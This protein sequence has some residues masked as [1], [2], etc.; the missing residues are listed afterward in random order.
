MR[1]RDRKLGCVA[2]VDMPQHKA[3]HMVA[4]EV[5]G[6]GQFADGTEAAGMEHIFAPKGSDDR[7]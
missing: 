1:E 2:A 4:D 5:L 3:C 6:P 7:G